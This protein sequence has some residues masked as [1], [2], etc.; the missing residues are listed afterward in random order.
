M[1]HLRGFALFSKVL[2]NAMLEQQ[3]N[4][5]WACKVAGCRFLYI[6]MGYGYPDTLVF[7]PRTGPC[8]GQ[9]LGVP[10]ANA[11][12]L[13]IGYRVTDAVRAASLLEARGQVQ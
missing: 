7:T 11:H 9:E 12:P 10:L 3:E 4:C 8:A 2:E 13:A 1:E 6:R 5:Q